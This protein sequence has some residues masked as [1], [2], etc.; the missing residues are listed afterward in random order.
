MI[1]SN[2]C[3]IRFTTIVLPSQ[4]FLKEYDCFTLAKSYFDL[5]EY[6][7]AAYFLTDC[8]SSKGYF[9]HMYSRYMSGEKKK[10]DDQG[11]SIGKLL[12]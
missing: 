8:K 4:Q 7:R 9:L 10:A 6:D 2:I 11:D 12:P 5:K 1:K 3:Q